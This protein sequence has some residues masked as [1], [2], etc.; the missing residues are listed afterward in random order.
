MEHCSGTL[1]IHNPAA[2]H[3]EFNVKSLLAL[4]LMLIPHLVFSQSFVGGDQ[5]GIWTA[6]AS[7]YRVIGE[8]VVPSGQ[9][10]T[11]EPGVEV[12]FQGHYKFTVNGYLEAVGAENDTIYFTTDTPAIGWGGIR[13]DSPDITQ[14]GYCRIEFGKTAGDYPDMHGGGLALLGSDAVV[15]H[16]V[17]ADNDA[18]ADDLGMGGAV[19]G[20]S[21]GSSSGPLTR[22]TDCRFIRNHCYGEG[23][24]I[25]FTGDT[26]TEIT[27]CEF[28]QNDC[29]YGGGA[30]SCYSVYGTKLT[31]CL[32]VDNYTMFSSGG[33]L[34]SLGSGNRLF[35]ANCTFTG[36]TAVTGD[37]GA[38][39][40]AYTE[41]FI[42]N[43]I[44]YD[45]PGMYS[46]DLF[47]DW[48]ASAEI[49]HSNLTMPG[50]ATGGNNIDTNP[51]FVD[52]A[53]YDFH[54]AEASPCVDAG[55][56]YIVL[57]GVTLVD[58][59]ADEYCGTAPD[60]GA[61]EFCAVSGV[62]NRTL[63]LFEVG[64][65]YPNPFSTRTAVS[66]RLAADVFV[67]AKV[68]NVRGHEIRT[69]LGT[70][71]AAGPYSV[72]W[73]GKNDSGQKVSQGLYFLRLQ[74]GDEVSSVRLLLTK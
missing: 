9:T 28:F 52:A 6:A 17:F 68:Y 2:A 60:M 66:Y 32:F 59:A 4:I 71:Q 26:N 19:Y 24:A 61:Y 15:S 57:G 14:L 3:T 54:L 36:N 46:D 56:D 58:L 35:L 8:V 39:N 55:T 67:S 72:F 29:L 38:L 23:G 30:I 69:L 42:A 51:Q 43:S 70:R 31:N 44:V 33:A 25:K 18:T 34:N 47:L 10:L 63:S 12:N 41:A 65:N 7:P 64:L 49:H 73:D 5:S 53:N 45:N 1:V 11:I 62:E 27:N 37:G 22:F 40:L 21:T 13:I 48:G 16:C 74:A 50:G 20:I